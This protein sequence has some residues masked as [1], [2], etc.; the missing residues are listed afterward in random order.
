MQIES[1]DGDLATAIAQTKA[2]SHAWH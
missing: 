1:L 2:C